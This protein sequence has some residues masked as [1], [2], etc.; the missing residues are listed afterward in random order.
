MKKI[1]IVEAVASLSFLDAKRPKFK[2]QMLRPPG[3]H[4]V[5]Y[6]TA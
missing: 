3:T 5:I 4:A 2:R 1:N 6:P